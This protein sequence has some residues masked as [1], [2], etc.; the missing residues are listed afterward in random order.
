MAIVDLSNVQDDENLPPES[1]VIIQ[2]VHNEFEC[3]NVVDVFPY[4]ELNTT[5]SLENDHMKLEKE[6]SIVKINCWAYIL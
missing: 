3:P 2:S 5:H 1:I 4:D 6:N